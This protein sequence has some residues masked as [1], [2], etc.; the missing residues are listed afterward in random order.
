M[1]TEPK[2]HLLLL[3]GGQ[4]HVFLLR[5]LVL[6]PQPDLRV[7]LLSTHSYVSY[8]PMVPGFLAG[9]YR[10]EEIQIDLR[11]LAARAGAAF[12]PERVLRID[13]ETHLVQLD[14]RPALPYELLSIDLAVEPATMP[15]TEDDG[16]AVVKPAQAAAQQIHEAFASPAPAAG[17][18]VVIIGAG[19]PGVEIAFG[20]AARLRWEG[21]G[22]LTLVDRAAM[23]VAE[24]DPRLSHQVKR[25]LQRHGAEFIGG[26][27]AEEVFAGGVYLSDGRQLPADLVI[28]ATGGRGPQLLLD[29]D[30][31]VNERGFLMVGD[32]LRCRAFPE[33]FASGECVTIE[34]YPHLPRTGAISTREAEL[35][36]HNVRAA[37][38]GAKLKTFKP[39]KRWFQLINTADG[40]AIMSYSHVTSRGRA[41][42][43]LKDRS[44]RRFIR[45][46]ARPVL[47]NEPKPDAATASA[48]A[49]SSSHLPAKVTAEVL[50][51]VLCRLDLPR[52]EAILVGAEDGDDAAVFAHP[53]GSL[54]VATVD[55]LPLFSDDFYFVGRV[56]ASNAA[57]DL[58]AMGAEGTAAMAMVCLPHCDD[59]SAE[60]HLEHFLSG[61]LAQLS[62]M[63]IALAGGHT[64]IGNQALLGFSM[65]GWVSPD[66]I[67]RKS[68][69]QPGDR[70]VLTK[71][72]GSGVI[73]A[74]AKAGVAAAEWVD[75]AHAA[76]VQSNGAAMR[77]LRDHGAHA[78]T[79]VTGFGLGGHLSELLRASEVGARL[80]GLALPA[81]PGAVELLT[82]SWRSEA[83]AANE[84]AQMRGYRADPSLPSFA[85]CFD[86]QISGGLLAA[87][88]RDRL[89]QMRNAFAEAGEPFAE[90]GEIYDGVPEWEL[91]K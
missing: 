7:T 90:I 86:P 44:D 45:E 59:R 6:R 88:P 5:S 77:L 21:K 50:E 53:P 33:I 30:L 82:A 31:P 19:T 9:Q 79:D 22:S 87:V 25:A 67:L 68:G 69:A 16:A 27:D 32:D 73:L 28:W 64:M 83:H 75:A 37:A 48:P 66:R 10:L 3:G 23:P 60:Q 17:R 35:L 46:Y 13:P 34:N 61:A 14:N 39:P 42:W 55:V 24:G 29:S 41:W 20:V 80:Y 18:R 58:Y 63:G 91:E 62:S 72:L 81:L 36:T 40:K 2:R 56:A 89:S 51:R 74:A 1:S 70:L 84:R 47:K 38:A 26:V 43:A 57:S 49:V 54:A 12:M 78:C 65:H 4:S 8:P 15:I 85:L 71:P 76:M 11:S 52:S